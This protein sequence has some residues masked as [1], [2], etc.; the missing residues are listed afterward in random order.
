VIHTLLEKNP[1]H[2]FKSATQ[3]T[4]VLT[5]YLAHLQEPVN[6][7]K[8]KI[9]IPRSLRK[10]R[11]WIAATAVGM[12]LSLPA[13]WFGYSQWVDANRSA[14]ANA[15]P[16]LPGERWNPT[17]KPNPISADTSK[18]IEQELGS[19]KSAVSV[20]ENQPQLDLGWLTSSDA[21][22]IESLRRE[23]SRLE[24]EQMFDRSRTTK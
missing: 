17:T 18:S 5:H 1:D 20:L 21:Q 8:P 12:A 13:G 7:Q 9:E 19:L 14:P 23:L 15:S 6:R 11:R 3:V 22:N 16:I 24:Q 2:R 4:E 10:S